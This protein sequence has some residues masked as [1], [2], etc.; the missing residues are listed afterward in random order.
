MRKLATIQRI[1]NLT[2]IN[3]GDFIELASILGWKV[4]VKKGEFHVNSLVVYVEID[5]LLPE[6]PEFEFLR[7]D[8]F[9]IRT[10]KIKG[11]ISQGIAFPL[12]IIEKITNMKR[13]KLEEGIDLTELLNIRLYEPSIPAELAGDAKGG[14]PGFMMITNEERIQILPHIPL[15][16]AGQS[17]VTTEKLDG[18]LDGETLI[19]TEDGIKT[20]K[21]ICDIQYFGKV[22]TFDFKNNKT[23]FENILSHKIQKNVSVKTRLINENLP[24]KWFKITLEN[25]LILILTENHEIWLPNLSCWRRADELIGNEEFL[26]YE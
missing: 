2:P 18:C 4:V 12:D 13:L 6:R 14:F 1:I 8:K 25:G 26:I 22:K 24:K 17:F 21:E 23:K 11:V 10:K 3:G 19:E 20:I 7:N 9:R 5:S 15:E 16:Y